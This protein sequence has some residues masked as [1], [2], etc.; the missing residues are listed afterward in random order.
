M[1]QKIDFLSE[2]TRTPEGHVASH[3]VSRFGLHAICI[4]RG[5]AYPDRETWLALIPKDM[6]VQLTDLRESHTEGLFLGYLWIW[7]KKMEGAK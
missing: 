2:G 7:C 1:N 4:E 6:R 3:T 5:G